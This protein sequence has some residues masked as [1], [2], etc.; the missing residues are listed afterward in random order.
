MKA[1]FA[2]RLKLMHG[3]AHRFQR[4]PFASEAAALVALLLIMQTFPSGTPGS[5]FVVGAVGAA[6]L[7]LNAIGMVLVF[8]SNRFLNFAQVQI[9][10]F[11]ATVFDGLV[12]G[13]VLLHSLHKVCDSCVGA[14]PDRT[15]QNVNFVI[16]A[17]I[18]LAVAGLLS[19]FVYVVV[20]RRFAK[21]PVL[22]STIV[23]VF[24][25]QALNGFQS[26]LS[27]Q[28]VPQKDLDAGRALQH[29]TSPVTGTFTVAGFPIQLPQLT[30]VLIVPIVLIATALYLRR[31]D[32]GVA[33]RAAADN[34]PRASTLGVDVATVTSRV[35]M[36]A[37]L[38]SG[39]AAVVPAFAGAASSSGT[40][41]HQAPTIPIGQLVVL[42]TILVIARFANLWFVAAGAFVLTV[43]ATAVQLS[44]SSQAPLDATYAL[45]VGGLL[46][47]QRDR[48]TRASREDFSGLEVTRELRPIPH[49]LKGLP[50]VR[51]YTRLGWSLGAIILLG[52]P[53][54]ISLAKTSLLTDSLGLAIVG[55]SLLVLTGWGGQ[56]SLGQFGFAAIGAWAAACSGLPFP[57]A[58]LLAGVAGGVAAIIVGLPALKLQGLNLAISTLAFSVSANALFIDPRYLG[59]WL[60]DSLRMPTFLGLDFGDE[61]ATYYLTLTIV[62]LFCAAVLGLRRTRTGRVLIAIRA[63]EATAQS[64]GINVLR[65]RLTAFSISGFMAAVAGALLAY[66]LGRVAPAAFAP[67]K[68]LIV[69]L[70]AVL[71]GL[72]G[73][74]GPLLGMAFYAAVTFFFADN[75]LIQYAGAGTGAVLLMLAAPGGLAQLVYAARDAMLRRVAFRLRIPVP[76]LMGDKGASMAAD[77]VMLE[78]KRDLPRRPG[79]ALPL[80][81]KP[82]GQ[83]ALDRL[84][85]LD[86]PKERVGVN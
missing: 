52:L 45:L 13:Q 53:Y 76:S 61:R 60:P 18:G 41:D 32:T 46:L 65:A 71:G 64:F 77:R 6:P 39:L 42:L 15:A 19:V 70:F 4:L 31:S 33:I 85:R 5:V 55:L 66:H 17:V 82:P 14:F 12:R 54:S 47:L 9:G 79:E 23:T 44:F 34:P 59:G 48:R 38:L 16:S 80:R 50:V 86:G 83:W 57:L 73:L 10:L 1:D 2:S 51:K 62:L 75:A 3:A 58:I 25:A 84:G 8:R 29:V 22:V 49:E 7:I 69:F 20:V 30:L 63:N 11:G 36:L 72:G 74:A 35:W 68:S 21:S 43:L 56:V 40:Q 27:S 78:E 81:Y 37:G 24:L 67:D 28:M 26:S